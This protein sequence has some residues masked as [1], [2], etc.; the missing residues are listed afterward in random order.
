M[1]RKR[2]AGWRAPDGAVYVG[3]GTKWGNPFI[4][5]QRIRRAKT[6]AQKRAVTEGGPECDMPPVEVVTPE[7]A[8]E[9]FRQMILPDLPVHQLRGKNLLCWCEPGQPC[10]GDILLEEANR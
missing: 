9:L 6:P 4:V 3:R 7:L 2:K 10:H 1:Q 5:G 8:C